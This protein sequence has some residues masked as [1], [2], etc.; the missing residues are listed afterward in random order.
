[1]VFSNNKNARGKMIDPVSFEEL[2]EFP[3]QMNNTLYNSGTIRKMIDS[4]NFHID[5]NKASENEFITSSDDF[6][7]IY[8]ANVDVATRRTIYRLLSRASENTSKT[9]SQSERQTNIGG[10]WFSKKHKTIRKMA[11]K[12]RRTMRKLVKRKRY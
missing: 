4:Q 3:I 9:R 7:D 2:E 5:L 6:K 12:Y 1:M 8:N 11:K 10:K